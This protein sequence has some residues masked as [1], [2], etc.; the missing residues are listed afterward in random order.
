MFSVHGKETLVSYRA[1]KLNEKIMFSEM[2]T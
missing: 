2:E 1:Q